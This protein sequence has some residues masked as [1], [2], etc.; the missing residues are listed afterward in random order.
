MT[1]QTFHD[2][3]D[4]LGDD[5]F[6]EHIAS[7]LTRHPERTVAVS[8]RWPEQ[9]LGRVKRVAE[10]AGVPYQ[11]LIKDLVAAALPAAEGHTGSTP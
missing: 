6:D 9:L 10:S 7:L 2:P 11:T 5:E 3:Y 4:S 8:I 1:R